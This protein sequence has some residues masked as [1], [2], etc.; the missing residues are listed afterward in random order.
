VIKKN[1]DA[2]RLFSFSKSIKLFLREASTPTVGSSNIKMLGLLAKAL[3]I[4][5]R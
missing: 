2:L 3:A 1:R 5:T 4:K